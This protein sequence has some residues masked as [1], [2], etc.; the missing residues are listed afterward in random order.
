MN[1]KDKKP[2]N[3]WT[4]HLLMYIGV[5]FLVVLVVEMME[6]GSRTTGGQAMAYS[7]FVHQV[8]GALLQHAGA[9]PGAHVLAAGALDDHRLDALQVQ[10]LRQHEPGRTGADDAHLRAHHAASA[11]VIRPMPVVM[12]A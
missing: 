12:G 3:P 11:S 7:E 8:D 1:D 6:G 10:D 9:Q 2:R 4:R 5:V